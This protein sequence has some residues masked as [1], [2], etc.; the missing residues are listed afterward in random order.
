MEINIKPVT[1]FKD[2]ATKLVIDAVQVRSLGES[3]SAMILYALVDDEGKRV[4]N[5]VVAMNG[6]DYSQWGSDDNYVLNHL[7]SE[8]ELQ[9]A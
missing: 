9:A 8:L 6:A 4:N 7:M 3:G 5:G 2:K 1:F